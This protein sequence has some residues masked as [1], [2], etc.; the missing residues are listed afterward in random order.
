MVAGSC[1]I[2]L[3]AVTACAATAVERLS[4][5]PAAGAVLLQMCHMSQFVTPMIMGVYVALV[6][7]GGVVR[8]AGRCLVERLS[9]IVI[10]GWTFLF[11]FAWLHA[12]GSD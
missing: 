3:F 6:L 1:G 12:L 9:L 7:D 8:P 10:C 4:L 11:V 2:A 5:V